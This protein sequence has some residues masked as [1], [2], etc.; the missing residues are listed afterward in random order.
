[1]TE[2][3][4]TQAELKAQFHYNHVSGKFI[5]IAHSTQQNLIGTV[6]GHINNGYVEIKINNKRYLAHRLAWLFMI[7]EFP[8][9]DIDHTDG[10]RLNNVFSNLRLASKSENR[11]NCGVCKNNT[12]GF[13]GVSL[14]KK[15]GKWQVFCKANGKNHYLGLHLTPELASQA[16]EKFAKEHHKDF[17]NNGPLKCT[18]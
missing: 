1:M 8:V 14:H 12:S 17:F 9:L 11:M 18:Q 2:H 16:Y 5:Y 4:L 15:S 13:K 7:G 3:I 10:N 6:A